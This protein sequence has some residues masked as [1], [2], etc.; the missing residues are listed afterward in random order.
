M[1]YRINKV[2][3]KPPAVPIVAIRRGYEDLRVSA[4]G[5]AR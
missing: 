3:G 5:E 1:A 2:G 4:L